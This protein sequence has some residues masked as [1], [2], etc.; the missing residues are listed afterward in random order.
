MGSPETV[1]C[2]ILGGG[3]HAR[4]VIDGIRMGTGATV[5]A[6]LDKDS[7]KWGTELDGVPIWGNDSLI[8]ETRAKGISHF[9][10]AVGGTGDNA[11]RK[12]L[13]D[14]A[15]KSGLMPLSV[16]H[17]SAV[18]AHGVVIGRGSFIG[19]GAILGPGAVIGENVIINSGAIVEHDCQVGDHVHV[20]S[21]A[22]LSGSVRIG[23]LAHI[24]AGAVSLQGI[25]IGRASVVGAGA[26]VIHDVADSSRVAGVPATPI[27][28]PSR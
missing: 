26:V 25:Q 18:C 8:P 23:S 15:A 10:V 21:A 16:V 2:L 20:A 6:I 3:G 17:P 1:R 28:R 12:A 7:D 9:I 13:F 4:V 27:S 14:H 5:D 11:V 24:G 19:P 22:C